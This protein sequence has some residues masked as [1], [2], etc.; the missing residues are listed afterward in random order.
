MC[1]AYEGTT[2][3]E[4]QAYLARSIG[5]PRS[6]AAA[7][8]RMSQVPGTDPRSNHFSTVRWLTLS[9]GELS[10]PAKAIYCARFVSAG[11]QPVA[12]LKS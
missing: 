8:M 9:P 11:G 7:A 1:I 6:R 5:R 3:S 12:S 10:I 4:F 2:P